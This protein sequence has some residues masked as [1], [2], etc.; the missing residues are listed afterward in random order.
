MKFIM[1]YLQNNNT[2]SFCVYIKLICYESPNNRIT[3]V[4]VL[5]CIIF[6]INLMF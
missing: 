5:N 6:D 4:V 2:K 1:N 3:N